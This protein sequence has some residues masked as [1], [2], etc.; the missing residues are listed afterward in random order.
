MSISLLKEVKH[1]GYK[2][3]NF[4]AKVKVLLQAM[5]LRI[6]RVLVLIIQKL[7]TG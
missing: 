6:M 4:G 2:C 1:W 5:F 7:R 3:Q